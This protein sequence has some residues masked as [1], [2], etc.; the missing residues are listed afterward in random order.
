MNLKILK[1]CIEAE[2]EDHI[3]EV[4]I[5]DCIL[6]RIE[7]KEDDSI[8]STE[9]ADRVSNDMLLL[10]FHRRYENFAKTFDA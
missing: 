6:E 4:E 5:W 9:A 8:D 3:G 1:A 2:K 7:R 10:E